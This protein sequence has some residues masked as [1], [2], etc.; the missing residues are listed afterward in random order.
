MAPT[1]QPFSWVP[2][3]S[4]YYLTQML[5]ALCS[6]LLLPLPDLTGFLVFPRNHSDPLGAQTGWKGL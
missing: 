3:V 5:K 1:D 6:G 2:T 4:S